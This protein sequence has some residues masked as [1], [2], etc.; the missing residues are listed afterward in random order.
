MKNLLI[1]SLAQIEKS[2]GISRNI[3]IEMIE[4]SLLSVCKK[5]YEGAEVKVSFNPDKGDL[6]V[7]ILKNVVAK[8]EDSRKEIILKDARNIKKDAE[9]GDTLEVSQPTL[10]FSRII[11]QA[12]K[13]VVTQRIREAERDIVFKEFKERE[14]D[15]AMGL[16]R[17]IEEDAIFVDLGKTE[18]VL[19][20]EEQLKRERYRVGDRIKAYIVNVKDV[21]RTTRVILSRTHPQLLKKLFEIEVPEI[22][23]GLIK[24]ERIARE[25]GERTKMA[26]L[27][28][29]KE[30]D[31]VGTCIGVR[32][33]R[34]RSVMNELE[35]EKIDIIPFSDNY[36][37]F[38]LLSLSPA[39]VKRLIVDEEKKSSTVIVDKDQLSLAIGRDGQNV[40]LAAKL[41]GFK[42]DVRTEEQYW[43]ERD[44]ASIPG[45]GDM[46]IK[47]LK[48]VRIRSFGDVARKGIEGLTEVKGIGKV[49]AQT[50]LDYVKNREIKD[51]K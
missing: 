20:E 29:K 30:L 50:I 22:A 12:V 43:E 34:I 18:A 33:S 8:V 24:I 26:V 36:E 39:K 35:G 37:E 11:A 4:E 45:V 23:E 42:L 16:V 7:F 25:P 49:K 1:E 47:E 13:Q 9:I 41:T 40:R 44:V 21:G 28:T 31:P 27:S 17:K 19:P 14:G 15:I 3:L 48:K 6:I 32:G 10:D 38:I 51:E 46:L 2:K 5:R